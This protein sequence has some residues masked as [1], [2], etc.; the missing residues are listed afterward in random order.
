M[1]AAG[2]TVGAA[3]AGGEALGGAVAGGAAAALTA[4]AAVVLASVM[5]GGPASGPLPGTCVGDL[6]RRCLRLPGGRS[7]HRCRHLGGASPHGP[8]CESPGCSRPGPQW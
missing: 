7:G 2:V 5:A 3:D 4:G 1:L 6:A 8:P